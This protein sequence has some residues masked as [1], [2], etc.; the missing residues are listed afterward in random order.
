MTNSAAR[1]SAIEKLDDGRAV[2]IRAMRPTDREAVLA[3]AARVSPRSMFR[4]FF[5]VRGEFSE[6]EIDY[7]LNVDFVNHVA[8]VAVVE[9]DGHPAI[10]GGARFVVVGPGKAEVAFAIIDA[11]QGHKLG[12][13]LMHHLAEL[14]RA[15]GVETMVADVLHENIP[16]LRVFEHSGYPVTI[17]RYTDFVQVQ[18]DL[19]R[20][21]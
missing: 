11:Y 21:S 12:T 18:I 1:Y 5:A 8:V 13:L 19:A 16:M 4:R 15:A 3:A 6:R 7:F 14:A 17:H 10:V 20:T 2:E 9:E